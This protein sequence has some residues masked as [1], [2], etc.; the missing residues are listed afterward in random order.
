MNVFKPLL[1][2]FF[3]RKET[4]FVHKFRTKEFEKI[5]IFL[6]V[7]RQNSVLFNHLYI[8]KNIYKLIHFISLI[9][10]AQIKFC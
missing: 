3:F 8:R 1:N 5:A 7:F 6:N 2:G 9:S 10:Y 4:F